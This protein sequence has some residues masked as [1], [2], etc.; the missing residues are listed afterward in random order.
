MFDLTFFC[1][2]KSNKGTESKGNKK[3]KR[4]QEFG[5]RVGDAAAIN[6]TPRPQQGLPKMDSQL[7]PMDGQDSDYEYEDAEEEDIAKQYLLKYINEKLQVKIS[8]FD[9]GIQ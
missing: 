6:K 3:V 1:E 4:Y 9:A 8:E 7:V 2:N 5:A